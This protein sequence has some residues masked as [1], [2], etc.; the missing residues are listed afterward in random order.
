MN[1]ARSSS[2]EK[3]LFHQPVFAMVPAQVIRPTQS[4]D[5]GHRCNNE[6]GPVGAQG[7]T[8][9]PGTASPEPGDPVPELPEV[10]VTRR[11]IAPHLVG[12]RIRRLRTTRPS[13]FFVTSPARLRRALAGR[14]AVGAARRRPAT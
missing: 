3:I 2:P 8:S 4:A 14:T 9:V 5:P 11:R 13:Y 1:A 6:W 10:E 7:R 12:R